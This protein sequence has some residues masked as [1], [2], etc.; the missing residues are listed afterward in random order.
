VRTGLVVVT[1]GVVVLAGIQ[2]V[3]TPPLRA[4]DER[5]WV[6]YGWE[7]VGGRLPSINEQLGTAPLGGEYPPHFH[8]AAHHPPLFPVAA[9]SVLRVGEALGF[10]DVSI[11]IARVL[12]LIAL[13]LSTVAL[14]GVVSEIL[15]G[16]PQAWLGAAAVVMGL[17]GV[18]QLGAVL[19]SDT[20]ALA[21]GLLATW[22]AVRVVRL[23]P[24]TWRLWSTGAAI[25]LCG[26]LRFSALALAAIPFALLLFGLLRHGR[27]DGPRVA[28]R[29]TAITVVAIGAAVVLT[30]GWF[31]VRNIRRYGDV[32]GGAYLYELLGRRPRPLSNILTQAFWDKRYR[33]LWDGREYG[34]GEYAAPG[35]VG[36]AWRYLWAWL[37]AGAVAVV[38]A[39]R[40]G[41][42]A[43]DHDGL[44][45][46]VLVGAAVATVVLVAYGLIDHV[47]DGGNGHVRYLIGAW[48]VPAVGVAA[49]LATFRRPWPVV[50]VAVS[51]VA[52]VW[53]TAAVLDEAVATSGL[54]GAQG[55]STGDRLWSLAFTVDGVG[56]LLVFV[57]AALAVASV[58]GLP[59]ALARVP[60]HM[61]GDLPAPSE[62]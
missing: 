13:G 15:P 56:P 49:T 60:Q 32:N 39:L 14:A 6:D 8:T 22:G 26:M 20:A 52:V 34:T 57:L 42:R 2:L 11:T 62:V 45:R 61:E 33:T 40:R 30:S 12:S 35:L 51:W 54:A 58:V 29:R 10:G 36:V 38:V 1:L 53:S 18:T 5:S 3:V 21:A 55:G 44:A 37:A 50:L 28:I 43:S 24:S 16:R 4:V 59:W 47:L 9:G 17:P 23:G 41:R 7:V 19:Y 48:W 46:L 27:A 31:Y 25:V